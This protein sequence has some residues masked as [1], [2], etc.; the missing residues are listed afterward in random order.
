MPTFQCFI[1]KPLL[2]TEEARSERWCQIIEEEKNFIMT[3]GMM[4]LPD[5]E[6]SWYCRRARGW[7]G[8]RAAWPLGS[9]RIVLVE[10]R[11]AFPSSSFKRGA[12]AKPKFISGV[13]AKLGQMAEQ[14][15]NKVN[16]ESAQHVTLRANKRLIVPGLHWGSGRVGDGRHPPSPSVH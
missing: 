6:L 2:T 15:G 16:V 5:W 10:T 1:G 9:S 12:S 4:R 7:C 14:F 8:S 3:V 11:G 13:N